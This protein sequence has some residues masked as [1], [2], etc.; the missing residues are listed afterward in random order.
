ML[1]RIALFTIVI[2]AVL[3]GVSR[4]ALLERV[5]LVGSCR[6]VAAP[7]R[8]EGVW[9]ECRAGRLEGRPDL[10]RDSCKSAGIV[11]GLEYWQC[12]ASVSARRGLKG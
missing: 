12:P 10:R 5:G 9:Q 11:D 6:G 3:F 8:G 1:G 2:G 4:G 7:V